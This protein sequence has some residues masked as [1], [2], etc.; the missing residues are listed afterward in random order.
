MG[1]RE[2]RRTNKSRERR[3]GWGVNAPRE[4]KRK[5]KE[6]EDIQQ[7]VDC[8]KKNLKINVQILFTINYPHHVNI[9]ILHHYTKKKKKKTEQC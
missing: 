4:K 5:K 6:E 1:K 9:Y 3:E 8:I 7:V 2:R